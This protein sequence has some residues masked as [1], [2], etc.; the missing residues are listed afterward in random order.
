[1]TEAI[2]HPSLGTIVGK[3]GDGI[4]EFLGVKYAS[5]ADRLA[6]PQLLS[7]YH[8]DKIDATKTGSQVVSPPN[9][10]DIEHG[11]LQQSLSHPSFAVSDLDGLHLNITVPSGA[12]DL[13]V[14]VF[15]HGG[16]FALGSNAWPQY[17]HAR[18]V[19]LSVNV[20]LPILIVGINYRVGIPGFLTSAELHVAGY[21]SNNGIRDQRVALKW[22]KHNIRA[23]GG[24]PD[25]ITLMGQSAGGV[26]SM[27]N[28]QSKESL[29]DQL[30]VMSGTPL[31]LPP[32]PSHISET[33]YSLCVRALGIEGLSAKDRVR[34]IVHGP[35]SVLWEN[36]TPSIPLL[37]VID[38]D[39]VFRGPTYEEYAGGSPQ[40]EA[41]LPGAQ[42][43]RRVLIGD[44]Q[45]DASIYSY[46][47]ESRKAGI[48]GA[49]HNSLTKSLSH[50]PETIRA[51]EQ[52][53]DINSNTNDEV[54]LRNILKFASDI[55][56]Y[57]PVLAIGNGWPGETYLY[58]FNERN[59]WEGPWKGEASHMMDLVYLFQNFDEYLTQT[60]QAH[61]RQFAGHVIAFV[62]GKAPFPSRKSNTNGAMVYGYPTDG[63]AFVESTSPSDFGRRDVI[64]QLAQGV[65]LDALSGALRQF[66]AS[67]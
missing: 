53:Y 63:A 65:G 61:A 45:S 57:A 28:L 3:A 20:G 7:N 64:L 27:L 25:K 32:L 21:K 15:I 55:G 12:K 16:G 29:F 6:D 43:C 42:W 9:G 33:A 5:L 1:M 38:D 54:A 34:E 31:G 30:I 66:L 35:M 26:A 49:F 14:L 8:G 10:C 48:A 17:N 59:P 60:E 24:A 11:F 67:K 58:H 40:V 19:K 37:P 56:F 18:L 23:F 36:I 39:V 50:S 62:N 47:L 46:G 41:S 13:P 44:C 51:L 52:A 2:Q 4:V 22:V